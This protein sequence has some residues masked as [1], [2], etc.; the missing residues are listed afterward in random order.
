MAIIRIAKN[1]NLG[2][3][4][5]DMVFLPVTGNIDA[6]NDPYA[7]TS[8]QRQADLVLVLNH[9]STQSAGFHGQAGKPRRQLDGSHWKRRLP[10]LACKQTMPDKHAPRSNVGQISQ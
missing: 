7:V 8:R 9:V 2:L 4:A 3:C 10:C 5:A 1:A 6:C